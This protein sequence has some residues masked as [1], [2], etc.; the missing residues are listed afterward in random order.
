MK[1][2]IRTAMALLFCPLAIISCKKDEKAPIQSEAKVTNDSVKTTK[3][4]DEFDYKN[5]NIFN[6]STMQRNELMDIFI[7]VSDVYTDAQAISPEII[8][9]LKTL[10]FEE[11]QYLEL[12]SKDRKKMLDGMHLTE[13]DSLYLYDYAT[14]KLQKYPI[15]KLKSVAYL[16]PYSS[17]DEDIDSGSYMLGF[18]L[19]SQKSM[20]VFDH[21]TTALAY[22]GNKSPFVENKMKMMKW[23]KIGNDVAKKFFTGSQNPKLKLG[24]TYQSKNDNLTYYLQEFLAE[25]GAEERRLVVV[26][27]RNEKIFEKAFNTGEGAEFNPL[28]GMTNDDTKYYSQWTGSL[29]KGKAPVIFGFLSE[30]FGCPVITVMDKEKTEFTINCDNRH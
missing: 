19:E 27:E 28:G 7:S 12:D 4:A 16:S 21:Y 25:Y 20:E 18:Q 9:K 10:S 23:E 15:N 14:S 17:E 22:F 29:F 1:K 3:I 26:N 6:V 5:F 13:N 8:K 24:G 11:K 2:K 30:S